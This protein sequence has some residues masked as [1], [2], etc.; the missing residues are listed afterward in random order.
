VSG[1]T[2]F[3]AG[4]VIGF[5]APFQL[6]SVKYAKYGKLQWSFIGQRLDRGPQK[7][8]GG[9]PGQEQRVQLSLGVA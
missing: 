4:F 2:I 8:A 5:N 7:E 6:L 3:K 1:N 9:E